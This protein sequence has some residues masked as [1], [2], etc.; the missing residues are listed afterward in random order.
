M[1]A[2]VLILI[3]DM[4]RILV[5]LIFGLDFYLT[6]DSSLYL[7]DKWYGQNGREQVQEYCN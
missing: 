7:E 6:N 4:L 2:G 5:V 1:V 3:A